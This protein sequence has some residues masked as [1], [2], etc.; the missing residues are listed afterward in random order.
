MCANLQFKTGII[1]RNCFSAYSGLQR[2][3]RTAG[4]NKQ[5]ENMKASISRRTRLRVEMQNGRLGT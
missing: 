4:E 1:E 5:A 3:R 2:F